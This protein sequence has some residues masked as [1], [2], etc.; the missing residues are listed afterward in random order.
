M[1]RVLDSLVAEGYATR[2]DGGYRAR[3]RLRRYGGIAPQWALRVDQA[4]CYLIN[5]GYAAAELLETDGTALSWLD[6]RGNPNTHVAILARVGFRRTLRELDAPSRVAL[7]ALGQEAIDRVAATG[8]YYTTGVPRRR[9][10]PAE[11]QRLLP[12]KDAVAV[13]E[14]GNAHG[15]RRA[16]VLVSQSPHEATLLAIAEAAGDR[17]PGYIDRLCE[18]ARRARDIITGE[19]A[20]E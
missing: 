20:I 9:V 17:G 8:H 14:A 5:R 16:A 19:G 15:V 1:V 6:R 12:T 11:V 13:D 10:S 4:F 3:F 18:D 7:A 2:G